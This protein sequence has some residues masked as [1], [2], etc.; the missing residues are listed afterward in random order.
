M[1]C[2]CLGALTLYTLNV[3]RY[4]HLAHAVNERVIKQPSM[5]RAG[6]LRDYQLVSCKFQYMHKRIDF[7]FLVSVSHFVLLSEIKIF[8]LKCY[9]LGCSGCF[10]CIIIS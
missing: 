7:I 6:T 5:L 4:Y 8:V 3:S 10:L 2:H 9:R 1:Q